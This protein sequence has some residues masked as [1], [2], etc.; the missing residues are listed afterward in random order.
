VP[1]TIFDEK[2]TTGT[3]CPCTN[4]DGHT[5][6]GGVTIERS[7]TAAGIGAKLVVTKDK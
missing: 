4:N 3:K 1:N 2:S 6:V 7:G 5:C